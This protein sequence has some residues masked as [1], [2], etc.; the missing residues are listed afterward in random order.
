V[1]EKTSVLNFG[2][3]AKE[4]DRQY[5]IN[6][7]SDLDNGVYNNFAYKSPTSSGEGK[8]ERVNEEN[9]KKKNDVRKS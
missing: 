5:E 7:N 6:N 4:L 1:I 2:I 3:R 8:Y 9:D